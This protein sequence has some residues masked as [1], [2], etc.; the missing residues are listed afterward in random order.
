MIIPFWAETHRQVQIRTNNGQLVW[1]YPIHGFP[2]TIRVHPKSRRLYESYWEEGD[3]LGDPKERRWRCYPDIWS[4]YRGLKLAHLHAIR[5][6]IPLLQELHAQCA[7]SAAHLLGSDHRRP[8]TLAEVA[9]FAAH[10]LDAIRA[11]KTQ[12]LKAAQTHVAKAVSPR[13]S[14]GRHNPRA[15]AASLLQVSGRHLPARICDI[16]GWLGHYAHWADDVGRLIDL[17]GGFLPQLARRVSEWQSAYRDMTAAEGVQ[18]LRASANEADRELAKLAAFGGWASWA[19]HC[20]RD[21]DMLCSAAT[22]D[23]AQAACHRL[24]LA[25]ACKQLQAD[26]S[27]LMLDIEIDRI[28]GA[29]DAQSYLERLRRMTDSLN[30]TNDSALRR[31]VLEGIRE[32]VSSATTALQSEGP[33]PQRIREA[34]THL[35]IA[36]TAL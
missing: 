30:A 3:H 2:K 13:D 8:E 16:V 20:R 33:M 9:A 11:P 23:R 26:F 36:C 34:R 7:A 10:F 18:D 4:L 14:L 22:G 35:R 1:V 12:A 31:P 5:Q 15:R 28:C 21:L 29:T 24:S 27:G 32:N 19:Q 6:R 17:T 25:I